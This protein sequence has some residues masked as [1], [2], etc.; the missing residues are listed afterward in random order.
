MASKRMIQAAK[1]SVRKW[2]GVTAGTKFE[3]G[4]E[5]CALC[6][7]YNTSIDWDCTDNDCIKCPVFK[8]GG[9]K[10]C[11]NTPYQT[12]EDHQ[13]DK[14]PG[15]PHVIHCNKCIKLAR[16]ELVYLK[17]LLEKL[18]KPKRR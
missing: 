18:E 6:K 12:W 8:D 10:Y 14:H 2:E 5:N 9:G 11:E 17:R 1:S 13:S 15:F 16:E 3:L 4:P 7:L